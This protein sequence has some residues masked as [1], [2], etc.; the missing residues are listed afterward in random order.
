MHPVN[1]KACFWGNLNL[2]ML[3]RGEAGYGVFGPLPR[4]FMARIIFEER[5]QGRV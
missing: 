2:P 5:R 1:A 4:F 3:L